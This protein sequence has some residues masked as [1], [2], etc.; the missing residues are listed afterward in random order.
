MKYS[1]KQQTIAGFTLMETLLA[2]ALVGSLISVFI[3]VFVPVRGMIQQALTKQDADRLVSTLRAEINTLH[4]NERSQPGSGSSANSYTSPFDKGFYWLRS[5]RNPAT[6]IVIFSYRA[7]TSK[8]RRSDG[9]YPPIAVNKAKPG[10]DSLLTTVV[11]LM[12]N[13][14]HRDDI[15][16]SVGPAYIVKL[17]Q[18]MPDTER[19]RLANSPGTITGAST[20]ESYFSKDEKDPW[21][22][23][24]YCRADFYA[25]SSPNPAKYRSRSWSRMGKPVFSTNISFRR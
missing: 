21:G 12:N 5:C 20:P 8:P 14:L 11:C 25:M 24:I 22:G 3:T 4:E 7:D 23:T 2:V 1:K 18:L 6:S 13:P 10:A 9:S 19:Y 17:T 16:H 15:R